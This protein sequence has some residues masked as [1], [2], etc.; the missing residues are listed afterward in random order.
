VAARPAHGF[1]SL[2]F[3][4]QIFPIPQETSKVSL[5]D[6]SELR[7]MLLALVDFDQINSGDIRL[8][9]GATNIWTGNV[10]YFDSSEQE[11]RP[12]HIMASGA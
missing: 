10:E 9:V 12:E 7:D 3:P 5:Y 6:T 2:R 1:F 4:P 8:S 11:I